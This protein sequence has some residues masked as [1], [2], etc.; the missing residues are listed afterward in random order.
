MAQAGLGQPGRA[1][2]RAS[3]AWAEAAA[4]QGAEDPQLRPQPEGPHSRGLCAVW[5]CLCPELGK[6][7]R[8]PGLPEAAL[9]I[10]RQARLKEV[11]KST[12]L[13]LGV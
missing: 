1:D 6:C 4:S 7:W 10:V 11:E 5:S 12:G 9:P 8:L 13:I 2:R 3:R